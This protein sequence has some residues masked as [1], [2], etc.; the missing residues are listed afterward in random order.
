MGG[1]GCLRIFGGHKNGRILTRGDLCLY[2]VLLYT[3]KQQ[4][5]YEF[6]TL[7]YLYSLLLKIIFC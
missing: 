6:M 4:N 5:S 2:I 7:M 1:G 3:Q